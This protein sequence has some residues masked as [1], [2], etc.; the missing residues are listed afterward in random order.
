MQAVQD[1]YKNQEQNINGWESHHSMFERNK[2]ALE[3]IIVNDKGKTIAIIGHGGAGT[4]VKCYIK[5]G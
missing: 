4:C 3:K 1:A 5:G 2:K